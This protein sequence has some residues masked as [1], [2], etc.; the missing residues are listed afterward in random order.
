MSRFDT[1]T[2]KLIQQHGVVVTYSKE[3]DGE[4]NPDTGM[5]ESSSESYEVVAYIAQPRGYTAMSPDLVGK[6]TNVVLI[7]NMS[8]KAL[9]VLPSVGDRIETYGID[10]RVAE[11]NYVMGLQGIVLWRLYCVR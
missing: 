4:Y 7:D 6:V 9:D 2:K 3:T 1:N 8:L 11:I 10:L 5:V